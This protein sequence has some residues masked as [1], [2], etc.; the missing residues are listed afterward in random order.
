MKFVWTLPHRGWV[1]GLSLLA[2]CLF[3]TACTVLLGKGQAG[4]ILLDA[5]TTTFP[6][7][8]TIQNVMHLF[9]FIALGEFFVRWRVAEREFAFVARRLLPEDGET[10]LQSRDLPDI[11]RSTV[12]NFNGEHG[13]L[14]YLIDLCILQF[15]ASR[16]VDQTVSVLNPSLTYQKKHLSKSTYCAA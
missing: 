1:F 8:F 12:G 15:Q 2:G 4:I 14:P 10:V 9:F 16:S 13:F 3:I 6:Y 5:A 11:R 7:P